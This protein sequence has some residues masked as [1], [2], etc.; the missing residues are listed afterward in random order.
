MLS[1]YSKRKGKEESVDSGMDEMTT[2]SY[3]F[4]KKLSL[5][6]V[7][8]FIELQS[9]DKGKRGVSQI[10]ELSDETTMILR[11]ARRLQ[12]DEINNFSINRQA[13]FHRVSMQ[14]L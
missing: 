4:C 3:E 8:R 2:C 13:S 11:A 9:D 12:P 14:F 10:Q 5:T 6:C 7:T 1:E